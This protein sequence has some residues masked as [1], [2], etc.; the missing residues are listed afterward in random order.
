MSGEK[1]I[2]H[3]YKPT[4]VKKGYQPQKPTT[5]KPDG[6]NVTGGYQ[7]TTGK[8]NNPSNNPPPKKP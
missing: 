8:G 6:G 5:P 7:P 4:T 3:G 1:L 2:D